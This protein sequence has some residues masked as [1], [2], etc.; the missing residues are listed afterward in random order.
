MTPTRVGVLDIHDRTG[1]VVEHVIL[2]AADLAW[3]NQW[4]WSLQGQ[5][6]VWR[7]IKGGRK[8]L[9]L[10]RELMGLQPGDGFYAD[11]INRDRLDNRRSN[12][13]IVTP[14]QSRQNTAGFGRTSKHRGVFFDRTRGRWV[15]TGQLGRRSHWIG[16]FASE[17]AA[18]VAS[19]AWRL[20]HMPFTVEDV[21]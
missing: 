1:A 21:A 17:E 18:A 14:A 4:R 15:A 19:R 7:S 20:E 8:H 9:F 3:A 16:A 5:G 12:L 11:H 2:D 10:H 13:R 6:Y